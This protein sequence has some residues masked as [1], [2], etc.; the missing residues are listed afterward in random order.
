MT[1]YAGDGLLRRDEDGVLEGSST[2]MGFVAISGSETTALG[3]ERQSNCHRCRATPN[4]KLNL[5]FDSVSAQCGRGKVPGT[6]EKLAF[7]PD[8]MNTHITGH[9]ETAKA[10]LKSANEGNIELHNMPQGVSCCR[11]RL[12]VM[13]QRTPRTSAWAL[14]WIR[15]AETVAA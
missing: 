1:L 8:T 4:A 6:I 14:F 12:K 11:S 3:W 7:L 5:T 13:S 15:H 2:K 10:V 9:M